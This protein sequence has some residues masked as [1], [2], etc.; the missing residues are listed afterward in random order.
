[1]NKVISILILV[2]CTATIAFSGCTKPATQ[3]TDST[4]PAV[5]QWKIPSLGA[6]TGPVAAIGLDITWCYD[7]A[8]EKINAAGGIRGKPIVFEHHNDED[9]TAKAAAEMSKVI[10]W[11]LVVLGPW[12]GIP[13]RGAMPIAVREGIYCMNDCAGIEMC[14]Q[15]QPWSLSMLPENE[16]FFPMGVKAWLKQEPTITKICPLVPAAEPDETKLTIAALSGAEE[17]GI[18][19]TEWVEFPSDTV[20]FGAIA[21]KALATG[22]DAYWFGGRPDLASK[23]YMEMLSRGLED[24]SMVC[25]P[26]NMDTADWWA[27]TTGSMDGVYCINPLNVMAETPLWE[28]FKEWKKTTH[29]V[30]AYAW[31]APM[32]DEIY[33]IKKCFEDLNITG[34]PTKLKEERIA[35]RDYMNNVTDFEGVTGSFNIVNGIASGAVYLLQSQNDVFMPLGKVD[36]DGNLLPL[37]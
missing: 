12:D 2:M 16:E 26:W 20:D 22:A 4:E 11:T 1:M 5:D 24:K 23:I 29:G 17:M 8:G 15:F 34:D 33:M 37:D 36:K 14:K 35:I 18:E 28:E 31:N 19:I 7:W 21:V 10:G 30:D 32:I 27:T 25:I 3:P 13:M 6:L 9:D